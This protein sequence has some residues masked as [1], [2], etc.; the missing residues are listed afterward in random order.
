MPEDLLSI[1]VT[2]V[3][4]INLWQKILDTMHGSLVI[5]KSLVEVICGGQL[6]K[7]TTAPTVTPVALRESAGGDT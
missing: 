3:Q 5:Y 6:W 2:S 4:Y 1:R 7:G